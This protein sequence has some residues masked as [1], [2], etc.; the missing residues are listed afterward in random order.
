M[1]SLI[2]LIQKGKLP[3]HQFMDL[4][5][6]N[7][8]KENRPSFNISTPPLKMKPDYLLEIKKYIPDPTWFIITKKKD[9]IHGMRHIL[10]VM[11]HSFHLVLVS[12]SKSSHFFKNSLVAS[13]LHDLRRKN[14]L[15]DLYHGKRA[16]RWFKKNI[17]LIENQFEI[18]LTEDDV[19]AIYYSMSFHDVSYE[20]IARNMKY[21]QYKDLTDI[22]KTA[23]AL[24]RY[25]LPSIRLWFKDK[26]VSVIPSD[27]LK[28]I[29]FQLVI[30]SETKFLN[31]LTNVDSV[32]RAIE[33]L[34]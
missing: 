6:V 18:H 9:S 32:L 25:R 28:F 33:E 34:P 5:T 10:R 17:S 16:A 1:V 31:G 11:F 15:M 24:D 2:E 26:Y 23:D 14:D 20:S 7:W 19:K 13:S 21:E 22:L 29:A 30:D 8:I 4:E 3:L 27:Y 12:G